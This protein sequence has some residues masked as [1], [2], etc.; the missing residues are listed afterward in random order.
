MY[1][2]LE[3]LNSENITEFTKANN[4][5]ALVYKE[6]CPN[7]KVMAKVLITKCLTQNENIVLAGIN[8]MESEELVDSLDAAR[9]PTMLFY[10]DGELVGKKVG[11]IK[12]AEILSFYQTVIGA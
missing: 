5:I 9:V 7:C 12:P 3:Q 10:K 6:R 4:C 8:S 11:I 2:K 1:E